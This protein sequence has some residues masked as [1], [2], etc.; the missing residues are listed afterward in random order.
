MRVLIGVGGAA[1]LA[2]PIFHFSLIGTLGWAMIPFFAVMMLFGW[3]IGLIIA[4]LVLRLGL[5]AESLAWAAIFFIQPFSAV[6]YPIA[7]LPAAVR[8]IAW[9]LP[10]A[11]VFEGMRTVLVEHRFDGALFAQAV[12][13]LA[14][15]AGGRRHGLHAAVPER[16]P[17]RAAAAVGRV[18]ML[19]LTILAAAALL[20]GPAVAADCGNATSQLALDQCAAAELQAADTSLNATYQQILGRLRGDPTRPSCCAPHSAPGSAFATMSAHSPPLPLRR[21]ASTRCSSRAAGPG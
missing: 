16:A 14:G 15:L 6:F 19:R 21:A 5:G 7:T 13:V 17:A 11:P 9:L 4:G 10:S 8:W 20:A 18:A 12:A 3:A 1:L 2:V